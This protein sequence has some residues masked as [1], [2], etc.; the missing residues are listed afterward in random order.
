[1]TYLTNGAPIAVRGS[2]VSVTIGTSGAAPATLDAT[3]LSRVFEISEGAS[4]TLRNVIVTGCY[5]TGGDD[6]GCVHVSG[7]GSTLRLFDIYAHGNIVEGTGFLSDRGGFVWAENGARVN[8]TG[9]RFFNNTA[10]FGGSF[11]IGGSSTLHV[12]DCLFTHDHALRGGSIGVQRTTEYGYSE[13]FLNRVVFEDCEAVY[14]AGAVYNLG[15][16]VV[17]QDLIGRRCHVTGSMPNFQGGVLYAIAG[18]F[19]PIAPT[20][21][22]C[23][24]CLFENCT[25]IVQGGAVGTLN[26]SPSQSNVALTVLDRCTFIGCQADD[27]GGLYYYMAELIL[28][29]SIF[30]ECTAHNLG[31]ALSLR[32][33]SR[34]SLVSNVNITRCEAGGAVPYGGGAAYLWDAA[35]VQFV[36]CYIDSCS[37]PNGC[38]GAIASSSESALQMTMIRSTI[39]RC[40]SGDGGAMYA[41]GVYNLIDTHILECVARISAGLSLRTPLTFSMSGGSIARCFG[42]DT[43]NIADGAVFWAYQGDTYVYFADV[44]IFDNTQE[45]DGQ[46]MKSNAQVMRMTRCRI[47]RSGSVQSSPWGGAMSISTSATANTVIEDSIFEGFTPGVSS[48]NPWMAATQVGC[49]QLGEGGLTL[50]N[51]TLRRCSNSMS[52]ESASIKVSALAQL[53]GS[54]VSIVPSCSSSQPVIDSTQ[55][56]LALRHLRVE[57]EGC[58]TPSPNQLFVQGTTIANCSQLATISGA[59]CGVESTCSDVPFIATGSNTS[60]TTAECSCSA[61]TF[62]RDTAESSA[63]LLPYSYGCFTPRRAATL[64]A[65]GVTTS[66]VIFRLTKTAFGADFQSQMLQMVMEGTDTEMGA[67]W[68]TGST[69]PWLSVPHDTGTL[70]RTDASSEF[71]VQ[72]TTFE[73]AGREEPYSTR[74]TVSV[75]S[76]LETTFEVP[77]FLF[78]TAATVNA[79]WGTAGTSSLLCNG[80][81]SPTTLITAGSSRRIRFIACDRDGLKN[82]DMTASFTAEARSEGLAA[83]LHIIEQ[84]NIEYDESTGEFEAHFNPQLAGSYKL[85]LQLSGEMVATALAI[86]VVCAFGQILLSD[87]SCACQAGFVPNPSAAARETEPC[88]ACTG[89]TYA[90]PGDETCSRCREDLWYSES[91]GS[92]VSCPSGGVCAAG[93]TLGTI[94]LQPGFWRLTNSTT[95]VR[96]CMFYDDPSKTPCQGGVVGSQ[97]VPDGNQHGPLCEV[98]DG[99]SGGGLGTFFDRDTGRCEECPDP[100]E[101]TGIILGIILGICALVGAAAALYYRPPSSLEGVSA[102]LH[103]LVRIT[104]PLGL[105]PKLKQLIAFFQVLFSLGSVYRTTLPKEFDEWLAWVRWLTFDIFDVYPPRCFG[106]YETRLIATSLGPLFIIIIVMLVAGIIGFLVGRSTRLAA[107]IG[108]A[109]SVVILWVLCPPVSK[110]VLEVFDCEPF[111]VADAI[112]TSSGDHNVVQ[113]FLHSDL[114]IRCS[115]SDYSSALYDRLTGLGTL[116]I[117][118]WPVGVPLMFAALLVGAKRSRNSRTVISRITAP[119]SNEYNE[120]S[121]YW[122]V[123]ELVRRLI[124]SAALL[125]IPSS[126]SLARLAIALVTVFLYLILL[127]VVRPFKRTDD[128]IVAI[129]SNVMLVFTFLTAI[130]VKIF[131]DFARFN[132]EWAQDVLGFSSSYDVA[133]FLI[134]IGFI[135]VAVAVAVVL[136]KLRK[137]IQAERKAQRILNIARVNRA[138]DSG[139]QLRHPAIFVT[140]D[141]LRELGAF[142]SHETVREQG[143]LH[144]FDTHEMLRTFAKDHDTL[145]VSHQWLSFTGPDPKAIQYQALLE[146]CDALCNQ[147]GLAAKDLYIW[148]ECANPTRPAFPAPSQSKQTLR[149]AR[150]NCACVPLQLR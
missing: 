83:G 50:R 44:D 82:R 149:A 66:S 59:S 145:F 139:Q 77:V 7:E 57:A 38:G 132:K 98:C 32:G 33:G 120:L 84:L 8:A 109:L 121:Y 22:E 119:L 143:R 134:V 106:A 23:T 93:S 53:V 6:G 90:F 37:A 36:D 15:S 49:I 96:R 126:Q 122:E 9:S 78:V 94:A 65:V 91:A 128:T 133:L 105:W 28:T 13:A 103:W 47:R 87:A 101:R 26:Y 123:L 46:V 148:L 102:H 112:T 74:L 21:L 138:I 118:I 125:A 14:F 43:S 147:E 16:N 95:D 60:L 86:E 4:L 89:S 127:F 52:T 51:V 115:F 63:E 99:P 56:P 5:V 18:L 117:I 81:A 100:G 42:T 141:V 129:S 80:T 1:M 54:Y 114:D 69:P 48:S 61:P 2:G 45:F 116:F 104:E 92:C 150:S 10:A 130:F 144:V 64:N 24:G 97:C 70:T 110:I 27:G 73:V 41:R 137:T 72:A 31:G 58:S 107:A 11:C 85:T 135:Q 111:G 67:Q 75:Q 55:R 146:A 136:Y 79:S 40:T 17:G 29:N 20:L 30:I 12:T 76:G 62:A 25:S 108:G 131:D 140:F 71:L 39:I 34:P 142:T 19:W 3:Y 35:N 68:S 88:V 113:W 124:I